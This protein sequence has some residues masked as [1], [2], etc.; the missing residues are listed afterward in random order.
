MMKNGKKKKKIGMIPGMKVIG[1]MIKTGMMAFGPQKN[2]TTKMSM[3]ISRRK[4]K[5]RKARKARMMKEKVNQEME[6][7]SQT[8]FN[9]RLHRLL[10]FRTNNNRRIILL[11]PQV[12]DMVLFHFV[13]Q[14]QHDCHIR[15]RKQARGFLSWLE[16]L[17]HFS[18]GSS[19]DQIQYQRSWTSTR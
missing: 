8:M 1:L 13:N 10:P 2:C 6:K 17:M 18:V 15:T 14:T 16:K 12:M 4:A 11:Q 19:D 5:E 3:D 7:A 9:L